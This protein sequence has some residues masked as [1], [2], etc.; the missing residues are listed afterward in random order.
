MG[1]LGTDN[2]TLKIL[3]ISPTPTHP[4]NAGNRVRIYTLLRNLQKLGHE[5]HFLYFDREHNHSH[6]SA[7]PDI[8]A[9]SR[10]WNEFVYVPDHPYAVRV[11]F[12]RLGS[13]RVRLFLEHFLSTCNQIFRIVSM[14]NQ[15]IRRVYYL[16]SGNLW[17]LNK[18]KYLIA[19]NLWR[20]TRFLN[21][22]L[23]LPDRF[24]HINGL[25]LK[26]CFPS[27]CW[28]LKPFFPDKKGFPLD[29][30]PRKNSQRKSAR[31][32]GRH[33]MSLKVSECSCQGKISQIDKWYDFTID[34]KVERLRK[35]HK[36]NAV[37]VEYVFLSRALNNFGSDV[38]KIIDTHDVFTERNE[39][40]EKEGLIETFFSTSREEEAKGLNRSDTI[41]AIQDKERRFFEKLTN[42]EVV[43]IGYTVELK[44]P[45]RKEATGKN[46]LYLGAGNAADI[47]GG[48]WF[49]DKVMP[50]IRNEIGDVKLYLAG[51]VCKFM[52]STRT[53]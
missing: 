19:G 52:A 13:G 41:I 44:R 42:K 49:I 12:G 51:H 29:Q 5:V 48:N 25:M 26:T 7:K 10:Y 53:L 28:K 14:H 20:V 2:R 23:R 8:K 6:V 39:K 18:V 17:R 46:P 47:H 32:R 30:S 27:L 21:F 35:K 22:V 3:I 40:H 16:I 43:T 15:H 4:Q 11:L 31:R 37:I 45:E 36:Y 34:K 38:L 50:L 33:A 24:L 1:T 9:M